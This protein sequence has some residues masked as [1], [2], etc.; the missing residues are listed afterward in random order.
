MRW[1]I[2]QRTDQ[3]STIAIGTPDIIFAIG[4]IPV[5]WEIK[6]P[7]KNPRAEQVAAMSDM[8][9]DGWRVAVIRSYDEARTEFNRLIRGAGKPGIAIT[10]ESLDSHAP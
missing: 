2:R 9:R 3:R 1:P 5:A 7:G 6:L 4:G 10:I 8:D